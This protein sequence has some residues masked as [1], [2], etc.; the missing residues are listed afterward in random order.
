MW[1]WAATEYL[2]AALVLAFD[3]ALSFPSHRHF[4]TM[5]RT[6]VRAGRARGM[7]AASLSTGKR[8]EAYSLCQMHYAVTGFAPVGAGSGGGAGGVRKG[9]AGGGGA[10]GD[11]P[12]NALAR[13][14]KEF[15]LQLPAV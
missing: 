7:V 14:A 11:A 4:D 1:P 15:E 9:G 6:L 13:F 5:V 8:E 10:G 12:T 2:L 3:F